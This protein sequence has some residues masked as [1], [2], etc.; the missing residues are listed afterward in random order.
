MDLF[1]KN[2]GLANGRQ[3]IASMANRMPYTEEEI[4]KQ[5]FLENAGR[6]D[7]DSPAGAMGVAQMM[8]ATM[9]GLQRNYPEQNFTNARDPEQAL[10]MYESLTME[11]Y[12]RAM[13]EKGA[14]N[15]SARVKGLRAYHG[16]WDQKNWGSAN[17]HYYD[18]VLGGDN[19][20]PTVQGEAARIAQNRENSPRTEYNAGMPA[21]RQINQGMRQAYT[22]APQRSWNDFGNIMQGI[23]TRNKQLSSFAPPEMA[24][25]ALGGNN[26]EHYRSLLSYINNR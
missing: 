21:I 16:G 8:P 5:L 10:R 15:E 11:N 24:E 26:A 22:D 7:R 12:N 20:S 2:L 6:S 3:L 25:Q 18:T 14:T 9:K 19:A 17:Q 23:Q 13:K 4:G 1:Y